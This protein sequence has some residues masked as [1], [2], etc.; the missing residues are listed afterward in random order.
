[1]W[2]FATLYCAQWFGLTEVRADPIFPNRQRC[3]LRLSRQTYLGLFGVDFLLFYIL[4]LVVAIASYAQIALVLLRSSRAYE[5]GTPRT[6]LKPSP[7]PMT[8]E[9]SE[10]SVNDALMMISEKQTPTTRRSLRPR[11][12]KQVGGPAVRN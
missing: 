8:P 11:S 6:S 3:D 12:H 2:I 10:R 1:M 7:S 9:D 4:P 5:W